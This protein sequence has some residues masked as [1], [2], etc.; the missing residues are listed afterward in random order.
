MATRAR[1]NARASGLSPP[2]ANLATK[3]D[4]SS[5]VGGGEFWRF[6]VT[7]QKIHRARPFTTTQ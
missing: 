5:V 6:G 2:A 7:E 4:R 1:R 3:S